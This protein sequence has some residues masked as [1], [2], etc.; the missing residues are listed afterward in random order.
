[1]HS[2]IMPFRFGFLK[3]EY[4]GRAINYLDVGCGS[5]APSITKRWFPDWNYYGIDRENHGNDESDRA[6][7]S[8]YYKL[9]LSTD[10]LDV[11]PDDF[12]DV[13]VMSHVIEHI[14]NGE[15]VLCDL[16]NKLKVGGKIYVEFP[17]ERSLTLPSMEGTL[18]FCDDP[19]HV[20]VYS[21]K[22][23][24]NVL[25]NEGFSIIRAG[26]RR[27]KRRIALFPLHVPL[28]FLLRKKIKGSDF[29]DVIGFAE[30]VFAEKQART[31]VD[32]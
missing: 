7:M 21:A 29:W 10:S 15:Q 23:I 17:S 16:A 28:K 4:G 3:R 30:F 27:D 25:L 18:N 5:H 8:G 20:R 14:P 24:A 32:S 1:M 2:V 26:T 6:V 19:T 31:A 9:D 13:I 11:V 22:E 12:F